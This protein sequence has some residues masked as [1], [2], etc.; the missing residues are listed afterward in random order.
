MLKPRLDFGKRV[1]GLKASLPDEFVTKSQLVDSVGAS[2]ATNDNGDIIFPVLP[3]GSL[4]DLLYHNGTEW[5]KTTYLVYRP[6][7][8]ILNTTYLQLAQGSVSNATL[9][10]QTAMPFVR[11]DI[12]ISAGEYIAFFNNLYKQ[13]SVDYTGKIFSNSLTASTPLMTNASKEIISG[14]FGLVAGT[15]AEGNRALPDGASWN[16]LYHNGTT[17]VP[18]TR[19]LTPNGFAIQLNDENGNAVVLLDS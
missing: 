3:T 1:G 4:G 17:W 15:F 18:C 10:L 8:N 7:Q 11:C 5:V 9:R 16:L 19:V 14:A 2:L 13:F 6:Y 12:T